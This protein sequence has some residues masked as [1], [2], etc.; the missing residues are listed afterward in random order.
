M[1]TWFLAFFSVTEALY[2]VS[3]SSGPDACTGFCVSVVTFS[4]ATCEHVLGHWDHVIQTRRAR[5][6]H[7]L[8]TAQT[9]P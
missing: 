8:E 6:R 9:R 5:G 2:R 1:A 7:S 3:A 4:H